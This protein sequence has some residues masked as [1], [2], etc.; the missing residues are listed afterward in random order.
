MPAVAFSVVASISI[1]TNYDQTQNLFGKFDYLSFFSIVQ[2]LVGLLSLTFCF[3]LRDARKRA[4]NMFFIASFSVS[5]SFA[6]SFTLL[7]AYF[8]KSQ[9]M[10]FFLVFSG[11]SM[12]LI[13]E[14]IINQSFDFYDT[15][16]I[17]AGFGV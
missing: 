15:E 10:I 6:L 5:L 11:A 17:G 9:Q 2:S 1:L 7:T 4:I 3:F 13:F 16:T 8:F 12:R 14:M